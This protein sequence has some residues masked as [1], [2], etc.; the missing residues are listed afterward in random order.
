MIRLHACWLLLV[1]LTLASVDRSFGNARPPAANTAD[2]SQAPDP[3]LRLQ[4]DD[5]VYSVAFS[6]DGKTLAGTL[7]K[8]IRL[9]ETATGKESRTLAGHHL[10]VQSV[11]FSPDGKTLASGGSD[12]EIRL[13]DIATGKEIRTLSAHQ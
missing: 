10:G 6:P 2:P 5:Y 13:W 12:K 3:L 9:W 1:G 8:R 11:A 4:H 7:D